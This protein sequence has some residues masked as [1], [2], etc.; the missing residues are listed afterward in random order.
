[1]T[2]AK[3]IQKINPSAEVLISANDIN[4]ITW[5]NGTPPIS[6]EQ[7]LAIIP[8]MKTIKKLICNIFHNKKCVCWYKKIEKGT[9]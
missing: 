9:N 1:M 5:L 4:Q 7:I 6:A 3:A 2:I 8:Q